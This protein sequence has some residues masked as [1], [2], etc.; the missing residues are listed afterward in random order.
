[1]AKS[2]K[3]QSTKDLQNCQRQAIGY[4]LSN[5]EKKEKNHLTCAEYSHD[6]LLFATYLLNETNGD[7]KNQKQNSIRFT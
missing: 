7:T 6:I 3:F 5:L 1:M 2:N 4:G